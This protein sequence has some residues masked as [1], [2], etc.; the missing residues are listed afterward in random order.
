MR[1]PKCHY[2]SFDSGERC[3]NCG[4]DFSL[5]IDVR[6]AEP[7]LQEEPEG[8]LGDFSLN[9]TEDAP[10]EPPRELEPE[11]EPPVE[12]RP[13]ERP[14]GPELPLFLDRET[15]S[16]GRLRPSPTP[17]PP[18]AVRRATPAV[19]RLRER[20][21]EPPRL[22]WDVD[23]TVPAA[24]VP[25]TAPGE[26]A[27]LPPAETCQAAGSQRRVL[28]ALIDFVI[29]GGIDFAVLYFT[30]QLTGLAWSELALLPWV[31][32]VTFLLLLNGAY[33]VAFTAAVGQSIGKM[34]VGLRVVSIGAPGPAHP[35][36]QQAVIRAA[37]EILSLLPLGVG[38]LPALMTDDRR[39]LHDRAARTRVIEVS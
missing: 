26:V 8:P 34:A 14:A 4:Y 5:A 9:L 24:D 32:L 29:L 28:A 27:E 12:P 17:R 35:S 31:P 3:R 7:S 13:P 33:L 30:V 22:H 37:V 21:A 1:C 19:P 23:T 36:A 39:A 18:L 2:I 16:P 25:A 20:P 38:L 15:H 10:P 11:A 6:E